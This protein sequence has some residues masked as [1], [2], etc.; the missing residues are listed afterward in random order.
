M[1]L[2][3]TA[4][5]GDRGE[6]PASRGCP[7][8]THAPIPGSRAGALCTGA[9]LGPAPPSPLRRWDGRLLSALPSSATHAVKGGAGTPPPRGAA[10]GGRAGQRQQRGPALTPPLPGAAGPPSPLPATQSHS[11]SLTVRGVSTS[12]GVVGTPRVTAALPCG[13]RQR[14]GE[15]SAGARGGR[16]IYTQFSSMRAL[17][18]WLPLPLPQVSTYFV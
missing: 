15:G 16:A 13:R 4:H 3:S 9:P 17:I 8:Q 2:S 12:D 6:S 14:P 10:S 5:L 1:C 7:S 18:K 11:H